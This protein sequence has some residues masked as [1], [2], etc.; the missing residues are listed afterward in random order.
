MANPCHGNSVLGVM[1]VDGR[2]ILSRLHS[3]HGNGAQQPK[4]DALKQCLIEMLTVRGQGP[5]YL[6]MD[7]L[8]ECPDTP[9]VP[10]PRNRILQLLEELVD[11]QVPSFRICAQVAQFRVDPRRHNHGYDSYRIPHD[12]SRPY[13]HQEGQELEDMYIVRAV[14]T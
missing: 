10:S 11:L 5:I 9:E 4:E 6:I 12:Y 2:H 7:A 1:C 13:S 3:D 14:P 8:D